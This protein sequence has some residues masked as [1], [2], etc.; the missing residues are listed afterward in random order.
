MNWLAG[1]GGE[2]VRTCYPLP[3]EALV[4]LSHAGSWSTQ[5]LVSC[6]SN[7]LVLM[8][9]CCARR[10]LVDFKNSVL[11]HAELLVNC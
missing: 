5:L 11:G 1:P 3:W 8:Q 10:G 9:R 6:Y 2:R 4:L 7:R